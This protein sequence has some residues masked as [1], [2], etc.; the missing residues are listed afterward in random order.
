MNQYRRIFKSQQTGIATI[1]DLLQMMFVGEFLQLGNEIWIVSPW[2][3]NVVLIDNRSGNFDNLNPE[4]GRKEI[5][6]IDVLFAFMIRGC[7]LNVVTR[8]VDINR[9]FINGL[10]D[11]SKSN[12]LESQLKI[13]MDADLHTKGI[14]LSESLLLGS[15][16][17]TYSGIELNDEWVQFSIDKKEISETRL[18]F[19]QQYSG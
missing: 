12:D 7:V 15:M 1:K 10:N 14:L 5:R 18:H 11:I 2:I 19:N 4:W 3:T 16:N 17:F 6:L 8:D 9:P 13:V